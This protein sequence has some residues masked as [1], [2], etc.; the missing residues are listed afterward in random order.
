MPAV[1]AAE[2]LD[3][4]DVERNALKPVTGEKQPT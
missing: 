2:H 4:F 3:F 1:Y